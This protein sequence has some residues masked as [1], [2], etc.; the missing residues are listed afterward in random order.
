MFSDSELHFTHVLFIRLKSLP[1]VI[2]DVQSDNVISCTRKNKVNYYFCLI[3]KCVTFLQM[4]PET[5][6]PSGAKYGEKCHSEL[7]N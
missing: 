2:T 7:Y 3:K 6:T 1:E 5:L 4:R